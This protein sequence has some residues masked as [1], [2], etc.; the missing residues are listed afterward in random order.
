MNQEKPLKKSI[1]DGFEIYK[2]FCIQCHLDNGNGVANVFPPLAK[3]D[4]LQNN[5]EESIRGVKYGLKGEITVNGMIYN[6]IM[7]QQGLDD[8]EIADVMNYILN[9]W[10]NKT[11]KQ[12]TETNV[13]EVKKI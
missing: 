8:E 3:S 9:N 5:L 4:Y 1:A 12:I 7:T 2:D 6:G 11:N 13:M 10:G